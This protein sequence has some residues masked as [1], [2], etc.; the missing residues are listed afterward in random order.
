MLLKVFRGLTLTILI[1]ALSLLCDVAKTQQTLSCLSVTLHLYRDTAIVLVYLIQVSTMNL[2][3]AM[4]IAMVVV[5]G[6]TCTPCQV[7]RYSG[8][9]ALTQSSY[10]FLL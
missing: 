8:N 7:D 1:I 10:P 5:V 9:P 6:R 2:L 3:T 4:L